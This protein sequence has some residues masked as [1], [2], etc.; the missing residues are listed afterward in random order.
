MDNPTPPDP[1]ERADDY[2]ELIKPGDAVETPDGQLWVVEKV[3][4]RD[5]FVT[6]AFADSAG[7]ICLEIYEP[8]TTTIPKQLARK[9]ADA[10][11]M[12]RP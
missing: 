10:R 11:S 8:T 3:A 1:Q 9:V 5:L 2:A 4:D 12:R 7:Q 6:S